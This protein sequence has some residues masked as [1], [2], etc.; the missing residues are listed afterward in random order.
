MKGFLLITIIVILKIGNLY[1]QTTFSKLYT[2]NDSLGIGF[3]IAIDDSAYYIV[4]LGNVDFMGVAHLDL[5]FLKTDYYGNRIIAKYYYDDIEHFFLPGYFN[6]LVVVDNIVLHGGAYAKIDTLFPINESFNATYYNF[7]KTGDTILTKRFYGKGY[8]EFKDI[9][10]STIDSAKYLLGYTRDTS[11]YDYYTYIVKLDANDSVLWEKTY[12]E[13]FYDEIGNSIELLDTDEL[14]STSEFYYDELDLNIDGKGTRINSLTGTETN[15]FKTGTLG[16]DVGFRATLSSD[17]NYIVAMQIMDTML[18]A[19]DFEYLTSLT[20]FDLS[21]TVVWRRYFNGINLQ[22]FY[23]V[24]CFE[25]GSIVAVGAKE[26]DSTGIYKGYICKLNTDGELQW[27]HTY[28]NNSLYN[29][30]LFDFQKTP[31]GGY[32]ASGAGADGVEGAYEGP[33]WLL[34]L[35]SMGCLNPYCGDVAIN[36]DLDINEGAFTIYPNPITS[37][38]VAEITVPENLHLNNDV[39]F[40]VNFLDLNGR[41]V[42]S[43]NNIAP[44]N[45]GAIIRFNVNLS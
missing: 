22:Y 4:G 34:K 37:I 39:T 27:E 45:A 21:G 7:D 44:L 15:S 1:S 30:F 28:S 10:Y 41:V 13:P 20:K 5:F 19:G 42:S 40:S 18:F 17:K 2:S 33:M 25:D 31:D 24:R 36:D 12:R 23:T 16:K 35:D 26:I 43:Y 32:I 8:A 29:H 3:S 9:T 6:N 14:I 11:I 38:G